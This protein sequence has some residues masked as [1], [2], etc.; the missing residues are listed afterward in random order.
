MHWFKGVAWN[1][2]AL[3]AVGC[4]SVTGVWIT[5]WPGH[6]ERLRQLRQRRREQLRP[7]NRQLQNIGSWAGNE[8]GDSSHDPLWYDPSW[9]V[10]AI[11]WAVVAD[12][13][14]PVIEG[15]FS[16]RLTVALLNLE[17]SA[18]RFHRML[19]EQINYLRHAPQDIGTRWPPVVQAAAARGS[20]LTDDQISAT[21]GL[22]ELDRRWLTE[23]YRRNKAVLVE[24][25]GRHGGRGLHDAW[26]VALEALTAE[27]AALQTGRDSRWKW[28]GH[29]TATVF[30]I[31]G[32]LFLIDF[33]W[34]FAEAR[35][36]PV[37]AAPVSPDSTSRPRNQPAVDAPRISTSR[38]DS[39]R[40]VPSKREPASATHTDVR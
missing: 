26:R 37:A 20:A 39:V 25:I 34:S 29:L 22:T 17:Q 14:Q 12:F 4:L 8:H 21:P 38:S 40:H 33:A 19:V 31:L 24:G 16:R 7:I 30:A 18:Q 1:D 23:L 32:L 27:S 6:R 2:L 36:R 10:K 3:A 5:F 35:L 28:A 13:N 11:D 15:D 9:R